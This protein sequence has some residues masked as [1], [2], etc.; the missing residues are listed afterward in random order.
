MKVFQIFFNKV[1]TNHRPSLK[2]F[3]QKRF[4]RQTWSL[5]S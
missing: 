4:V 1:S 3:M 2:W 5:W